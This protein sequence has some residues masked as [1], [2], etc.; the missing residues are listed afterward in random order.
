MKCYI[1]DKLFNSKLICD[2]YKKNMFKMRI[3][4]KF[5]LQ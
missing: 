1:F 3:I 5:I 4:D 2:V